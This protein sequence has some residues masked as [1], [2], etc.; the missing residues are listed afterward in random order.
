M[1]KGTLFVRKDSDSGRTADVK[2]TASLSSCGTY[3]WTLRRTWSDG[4]RVCW[5][6]LNPSTADHRQD[7]PTIRRCM[8]FARQWGF[9]GLTV[10]NLYPF[11]SSHPPECRQW[12]TRQDNRPD[13]TGRSALQRN[14]AIVAREAKHAS[15]VV[16]AWGAAAWDPDWVDNVVTKITGGEAPW[17]RLHCL[18]TTESG[19]PRH[20]L[21]RGTHRVADDHWPVLWTPQR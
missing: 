5:V 2:K 20:P 12:A 3:R 16:A 15:L 8:H 17:P 18:G 9:A 6:M 1:P 19:A 21:A 13:R 10:V 4:S 11:R 14:T 7:D